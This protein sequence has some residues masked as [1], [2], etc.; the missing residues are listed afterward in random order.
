MRAALDDVMACGIHGIHAVRALCMGL[1]RSA[2]MD[3]T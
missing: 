3:Q 2:G 1:G